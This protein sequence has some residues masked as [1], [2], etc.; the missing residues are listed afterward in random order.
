MAALSVHSARSGTCSSTPSAGHPLAQRPVGRHPAADGQALQPGLAQPALDAHR[1]RLDDRVLVGRREV[2]AP[3]LRPRRPGR[4]PCRAAAV[5]SP[6][7]E[8]SR[9]GHAR[10]DREVVGAGIALGGQALERGAA[11]IGQAEHARALV[12]G[13]AGG[14]V[15]RAPE[16]RVARVV[17][18]AG[19]EG[20]SAGGDQAQERRLER[21]ARGSSPPRGPAGGRPAPA[22]AARRGQALG[23]RPPHQQG[24]DQPGALGD[25]DE[26]DVVERRRRRCAARR[27]P[28]R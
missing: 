13:L 5:F 25:G 21:R 12:E 14:V 10:G 11:G 22:A 19:Q 7:K 6:A 3:G 28:R 9:P 26:L 18:D 2:G 17:L 16:D 15:E 24:A 27:R 20:V 23:R 4:A 1:E 8:K